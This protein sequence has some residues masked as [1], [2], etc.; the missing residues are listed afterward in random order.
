MEPRATGLRFAGPTCDDSL[1]VVAA[2][3][4]SLEVAK[5]L[6]GALIPVAIFGAGFLVA[7]ETRRY[8][9][10]QWLTR[11]RF[12]VSL[13]RWDKIAPL[14]NDLYCFFR[15]VGHYRSITPP[16]VIELKR[17]LDKIVYPNSHVFGPVF[18]E[19]YYKFMAACF[20]TYASGPAQNAKIRA[21]IE[22]QRLERTEWSDEWNALFVPDEDSV[23]S[24]DVHE[25]HDALL[26]TFGGDT[27]TSS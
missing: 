24:A 7:Q 8:D 1:S 19:R 2:G 12:E 11:K 13:E 20:L 17:D 3:W 9:E 26:A 15:C 27:L 22:R 14:L 6:V 10:R 23:R 18:I 25:A 4:N 21:S 5:L 16:R